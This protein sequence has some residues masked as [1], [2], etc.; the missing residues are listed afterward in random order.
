MSSI[1]E[2]IFFLSSQTPNTIY[3]NSKKSNM[4][5]LT[6]ENIYDNNNE[7]DNLF[8]FIKELAINNDL[9]LPNKEKDFG[10]NNINILFSKNNSEMQY[11]DKYDKN[12]L[13]NIFSIISKYNH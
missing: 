9:P 11:K 1:E 5:S 7:D 12:M 10:I 4:T 13:K 8:C 3:N 6:K 2:S